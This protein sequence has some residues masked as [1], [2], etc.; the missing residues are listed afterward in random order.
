M[1]YSQAEQLFNVKAVPLTATSIDAD[2]DVLVI[3][4]P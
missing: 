3:V 1:V 2:V 4:H